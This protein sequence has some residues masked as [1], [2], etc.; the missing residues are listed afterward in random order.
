MTS[1][2]RQSSDVM[3]VVSFPFAL[4]GILCVAC[5]VVLLMGIWA[6]VHRISGLVIARGR[7]RFLF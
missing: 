6:T 1:S 2:G 7:V 5:L 3:G 4:I